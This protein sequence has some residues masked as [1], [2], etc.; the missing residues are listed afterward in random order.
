VGD[1][2]LIRLSAAWQKDLRTTDL[3]CRLGGE[4]FIII[5]PETPAEEAANLAQRLLEH[6]HLVNH[7]EIHGSVTVSIGVTE[8]LHDVPITLDALIKQADQALYQAKEGGKN[9]VSI[10]GYK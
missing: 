8:F 1:Q 6:S 10:F 9:R 7:H 2:V 5:L 4:E 3:L